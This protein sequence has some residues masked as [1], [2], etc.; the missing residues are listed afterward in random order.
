[1]KFV[2]GDA[3]AG[4]I[5]LAVNVVGGLVIGVLQRGMDGGAAARV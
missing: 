3:I 5:V 4:I 1:V 2:K